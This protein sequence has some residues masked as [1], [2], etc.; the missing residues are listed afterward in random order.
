MKVSPYVYYLTIILLIGSLLHIIFIY[1]MFDI[2]F[3]FSLSYGMAP[4]SS[5]LEEKDIPSNRIVVVA[6][7][8]TR[9]DAF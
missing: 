9:A 5:S 6:L 7:D 8:G 2:F 4:H 1:S 3:K